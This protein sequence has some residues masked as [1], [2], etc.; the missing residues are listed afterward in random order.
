MTKRRNKTQQGYAGMTI[1]QGLSLERNE[2]A[3]Y[4]NVCKHLSNFKRIGDQILMPLNRK[5]RRLAKK[6]N[7]EITEVEQ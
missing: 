2:V 1:P 3:D 4:T 5:Q 6:L 7:I